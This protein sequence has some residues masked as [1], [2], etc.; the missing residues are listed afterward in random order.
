MQ[1]NPKI[2]A[3]TLCPKPTTLISIH[4]NHTN[5]TIPST[6]PINLVSRA[7]AIDLT[8]PLAN[9]VDDGLKSCIVCVPAAAIDVV[10]VG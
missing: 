6:T 10:G 5:Q 7:N 3:P 9:C 8:D 1:V 2:Y 4:N